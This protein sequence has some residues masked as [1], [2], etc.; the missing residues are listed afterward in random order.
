M[1]LFSPRYLVFVSAVVTLAA[2]LAL[3]APW[4]IPLIAAAR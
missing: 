4:W 2:S 3:G 1:N